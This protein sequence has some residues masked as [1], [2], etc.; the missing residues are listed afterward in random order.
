LFNKNYEKKK[1][2]R[3]ESTKK[4]S[5]AFIEKFRSLLEWDEQKKN[6]RTV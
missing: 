1:K 2:T 4:K 6:W 5:K 3:L